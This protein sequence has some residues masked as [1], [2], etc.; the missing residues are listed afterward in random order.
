MT[1]ESNDNQYKGSV[2][3]PF[4][5]TKRDIARTEE[6]ASKNQIITG[7]L[8]FIFPIGAAFYL[9]RISNSLKLGFYFLIITFPIMFALQSK[10]I[11]QFNN[12]ENAEQLTE[13][14]LIEKVNAI[15][16]E[17]MP[18]MVGI[19]FL[20]GIAFMAENARAITLARKRKS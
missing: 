16:Q 19:N 15:N 1:F 17:Y 11:E 12:I 8:G 20:G 14:Q 5:P 13:E 4:V 2:F 7:I 6:L 18:I 3:N 10:L 9:N